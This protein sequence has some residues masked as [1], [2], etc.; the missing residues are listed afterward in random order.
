MLLVAA[1]THQE[2]AAV[3]GD[4][5][6]ARQGE[7]AELEA[8]GRRVL[9]LVTGVGMLNAA[10]ETG[11]VLA[12][13]GDLAG[14][15]DVGVA[16]S[17]DVAT[18]PVGCV[19]VVESE[20][21]PEYGLLAHGAV[22]ADARALCFSL[23]GSAPDAPDAVFDTLAWDAGAEL[24]AMGLGPATEKPRAR[25]LTVSGVT[26]DAARAGALR[27]RFGPCLENM[28]GFA[29]AYVARRARLPF[30]EL[31]AVS[32]PTGARPPRD[33]NLPGALAA[34]GAAVRGLLASDRREGNNRD[35]DGRDERA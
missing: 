34:L 14:V 26:A 15:L 32:N 12:V 30:A 28:E 2:L 18:H 17:L 1:A 27:E 29:M 13:R 24:A 25:A 23:D 19:R 31:R 35:A 8:D 21:W 10:L 11:R 4:A 16:G 7:V 5:A 9:A 3:L 20:I 6:P 22:T 33:W